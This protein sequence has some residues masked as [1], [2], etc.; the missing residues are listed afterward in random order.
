[1]SSSPLP[2]LLMQPSYS[3]ED[4][5]EEGHVT[6]AAYTTSKQYKQEDKYNMNTSMYQTKRYEDLNMSFRPNTT[7]TD[8]NTTSVPSASPPSASPPMQ[9]SFVPTPPG[10]NSQQFQ[11]VQTFLL[12]YFPTLP[13]FEL[14]PASL[15]W[16]YQLAVEVELQNM[17]ARTITQQ[18]Q[19]CAHEYQHEAQHI[20]HILHRLQM[21]SSSLSSSTNTA[22]Q[23]LSLLASHLHLSTT[24]TSS[25]QLALL[26]AQEA[27]EDG[28]AN[29][30]EQEKLKRE[31]EEKIVEVMTETKEIDHLY[32]KRS[33]ALSSQAAETAQKREQLAY[34]DKKS[35]EYQFLHNQN[36]QKLASLGYRPNIS[37]T[38][39]LSLASSLASLNAEHAQ[40]QSML[41]VYA[42]LPPDMSLA[43]IQ[44]ADARRQLQHLEAQV[45]NEM[46]RMHWQAEMLGQTVCAICR[47]RVRAIIYPIDHALLHVSIERA[48]FTWALSSLLMS[49]YYFSQ[50]GWNS[51][52]TV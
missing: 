24:S 23:D 52:L 9:T 36:V 2:S 15:D 34:F 8:L 6:K 33:A 14:T 47:S 42:S 32:T 5:D 12:R 40:L 45:E 37:H 29:V 44:V 18:N 3:I 4:E 50:L 17:V 22:L 48:V 19:V 31:Y 46:A 11:H 49:H 26:E 28:R 20:K 41:S 39:L 16:L 10:L 25:F 21:T 38:S 30:E 1:M 51:I 27:R 7:Y 43:R 35:K 13:S